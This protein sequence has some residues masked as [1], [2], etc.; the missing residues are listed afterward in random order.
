[1]S[2]DLK[3]MGNTLALMQH[4]ARSLDQ[5]IGPVMGTVNRMF[6]FG[7]P[8]NSYGGAPPMAPPMR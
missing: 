2:S 4:S 1:M 8:G 3:Q 5:S 6:P 7:W